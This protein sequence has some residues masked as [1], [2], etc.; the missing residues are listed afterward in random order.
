MPSSSMQMYDDHLHPFL[1]MTY[2][3]KI[4]VFEKKL[5][6]KKKRTNMKM[7]SSEPEVDQLF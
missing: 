2:N 3:G 6:Q 1:M 5:Q 7:E 4:F